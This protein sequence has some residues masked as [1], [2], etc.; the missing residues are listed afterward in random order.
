MVAP[1]EVSMADCG[2]Y[3]ELIGDE[4]APLMDDN[5]LG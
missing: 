5:G 4:A 2:S 1:L 3:L